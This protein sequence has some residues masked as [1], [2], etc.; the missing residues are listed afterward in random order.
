MIESDTRF[1]DMGLKENLL[2]GIFSHGF[3]EPSNIQRQSIE[4]IIRGI[5]VIA[6]AQSGMGKTGAFVI[7]SL[8][9]VNEEINGIQAI[10]MAP[11]RELSLQIYEVCKSIGKYCKV[12]IVKCI[13]GTHID[14][15]KRELEDGPVIV[16]GTPGRIIDMIERK[17]LKTDQVKILIM[18]EADEMLSDSFEDQMRIII[19]AIPKKAQI[20][21]FSATIPREILELSKRI[22]NDPKIILIKQEN[23][24]LD[25]IKQYY[26]NAK[27]DEWKFDI[28]CKL[29]S[30]ISINQSMIYVNSKFKADK[31]AGMLNDEGYTVLVIHSNMKPQEREDAMEEFRT[32]RARILLSTDLL[33]RGIDVQCVSIVINYDLPGNKECYIH[34]IGR[35]GRY[36]RKGV[37]IN[38]ATSNDMWKIDELSKFYD[39]NIEELPE[40]YTDLI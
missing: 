6:Q 40:D 1:E 16:I 34:R 23:I 11:T 2:R 33:A 35:S 36:G 12:N 22:M 27:R 5:D 26:V 18:D 20:C 37:A 31:I 39:V 15:S 8:E 29:Y 17:Y 10:I 4:P 7:S 25:G 28:L 38:F 9:I 32:G 19:P 14:K 13:G 24:S 21:L 30:S 3:D